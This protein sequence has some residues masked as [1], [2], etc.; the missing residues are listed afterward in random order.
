MH[1]RA[2]RL[3]KRQGFKHLTMSTEP[4][5]AR[6]LVTFLASP[7]KVTKRRRPPIRHHFVIPCVARL[8]RRLRNSHYVLRQSSPTSP[9]GGI[10]PQWR[11][12]GEV[13]QK[14]KNLKSNM[15]PLKCG[16]MFMQPPILSA[17]RQQSAR[18]GRSDFINSDV[19]LTTYIERYLSRTV[20]LTL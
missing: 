5:V 2:E 19:E 15:M 6:Q 20:R 11:R 1:K 12:W 4:G 3:R 14:S 18:L 7:R 17:N 9:D 10:H 16:I 13:K 8:V